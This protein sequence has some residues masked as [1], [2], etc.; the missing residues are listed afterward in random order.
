MAI[1]LYS[2]SNLNEIEHFGYLNYEELVVLRMISEKLGLACLQFLPYGGDIIFNSEQAHHIFKNEIPLLEKNVDHTIK[3][4]E[5]IKLL[6]RASEIV[7][8]QSH[9]VLVIEGD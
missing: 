6:K 4:G 5:T 7:S 9:T 8:S 3:I 2:K 1:E